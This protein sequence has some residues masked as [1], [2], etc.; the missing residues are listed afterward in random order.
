MTN[1]RGSTYSSILPHQ[2]LE[3]VPG[4]VSGLGTSGKTSSTVSLLWNPPSVTN[5]VITGYAVMVN[6]TEVSS[7]CTDTQLCTVVKGK[8]RDLEPHKY[9][10]VDCSYY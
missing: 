9:V 7:L 2:L 3:D 8:N 6:G 4:P 10:L 5:G 1:S